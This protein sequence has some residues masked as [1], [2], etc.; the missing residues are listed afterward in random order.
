M[1][2]AITWSINIQVL[3]SYSN[4]C[5]SATPSQN[6]MSGYFLWPQVAG[7]CFFTHDRNSAIFEVVSLPVNSFGWMK[8]SSLGLNGLP[9]QI[10]STNLRWVYELRQLCRQM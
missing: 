3:P 4:I 10:R 7:G 8:M 1:V 5:L 9:S 6:G 2:F